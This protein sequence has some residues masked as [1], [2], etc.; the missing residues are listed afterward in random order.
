MIRIGMLVRITAPAYIRG[1]TGRIEGKEANGRWLVR[2][3]E[4]PINRQP[5]SIIFSL[6]AS[7]FEVIEPD[8]GS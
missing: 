7:E 3:E 1:M 2:L 4:N 8:E 5:E 6:E